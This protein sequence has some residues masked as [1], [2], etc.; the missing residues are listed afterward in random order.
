M[1]PNSIEIKMKRKAFFSL[2]LSLS[3]SLSSFLPFV[4]SPIITLRIC[5]KWW[6]FYSLLMVISSHHRLQQQQKEEEEKDIRLS[7][8]LLSLSLY[9]QTQSHKNKTL[10]FSSLDYKIFAEVLFHFNKI[11]KSRIA[12]HSFIGKHTH[13]PPLKKHEPSRMFTNELW[14]FN[15]KKRKFSI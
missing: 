2:S 10:P 13:F 12:Y 6:L 3:L 5:S 4:F 15:E 11:F 8:I 14:T 9:F 7:L 1:L